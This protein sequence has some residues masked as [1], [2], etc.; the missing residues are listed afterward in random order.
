MRFNVPVPVA[1]TRI[2]PAFLA[3]LTLAPILPGQIR[4]L[5]ARRELVLEGVHRDFVPISAIVVDR[6]GVMHVW[7]DGD[8]TIRRFDPGG[9]ELG[10][11]GGPGEGPGEFRMLSIGGTVGDTFWISDPTVRRTTF[12]APDGSLLRTVRWS[13]TVSWWCE[14]C[15]GGRVVRVL[16]SI[17]YR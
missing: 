12:F 2:L 16:S 6:R 3:L 14:S 4:P 17:T 1:G 9:K 15:H 13:P 7:Q 11:V 10:T 8:R 5:T